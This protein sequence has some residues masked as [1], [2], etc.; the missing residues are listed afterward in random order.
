MTQKLPKNLYFA[1]MYGKIS[2]LQ[3]FFAFCSIFCYFFPIF[4]SI[5]FL[6]PSMSSCLY[7]CH[8][9]ISTVFS[10]SFFIVYAQS[11]PFYVYI[12][13]AISS[14][15]LYVAGL[16]S[17]YCLSLLLF[18]SISVVVSVYLSLCWY[19]CNVTANTNIVI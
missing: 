13:V 9:F 15:C 8:F 19:I 1:Y 14:L 18:L 7:R 4:F 11:R 12:F 16:M 6:F 2:N 5:F 3:H 10:L 17:D